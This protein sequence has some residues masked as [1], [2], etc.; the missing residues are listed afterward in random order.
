M[1]N[2]SRWYQNGKRHLDEKPAS[3]IGKSPIITVDSEWWRTVGKDKKRNP[4]DG[5]AVELP[6]NQIAHKSYIPI[7]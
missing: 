4:Y 3:F 1:Q 2:N 6:S 7:H 5:P